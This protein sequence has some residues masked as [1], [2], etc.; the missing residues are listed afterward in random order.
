M[1][2]LMHITTP[3]LLIISPLEQRVTEI[4]VA[5]EN[6]RNNRRIYIQHRW[7][8]GGSSRLLADAGK[9]LLDWHFWH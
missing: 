1:L 9:E 6:P 8:H 3:I 4:P 2:P 5:E 7:K